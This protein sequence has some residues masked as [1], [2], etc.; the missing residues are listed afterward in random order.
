MITLDKKDPIYDLTYSIVSGEFDAQLL[1]LSDYDNF[2]TKD[3]YY[4]SEFNELTTDKKNRKHYISWE[5]N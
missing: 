5:I 3:I 4:D 1:E 2:Y